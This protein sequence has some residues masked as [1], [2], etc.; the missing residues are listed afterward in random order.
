[1]E[2]N[3]V[4]ISG[5]LRE[6]KTARSSPAGVVHRELILEHRSRQL[7]AGQ[8]REVRALVIVKVTGA[9]LAAEVD[10]FQPGDR[11]TVSGLLAQAS[12]HDTQQL[13]I[14]AQ[15]IERFE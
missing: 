12:H 14:H 10:R 5:L 11:I 3:T 8:Q 4:R 6:W 1:M 9:G 7:L 2:L 15:A 13:L